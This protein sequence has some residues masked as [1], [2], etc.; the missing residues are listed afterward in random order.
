LELKTILQNIIPEEVMITTGE[1]REQITREN[2]I[3]KEIMAEILSKI[4]IMSINKQE[5][6]RISSHQIINPDIIQ[7]RDIIEDKIVCRTK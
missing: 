1:V 4:K 5:I 3:L 7:V 6:R 2:T